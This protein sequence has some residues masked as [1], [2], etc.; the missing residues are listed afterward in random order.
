MTEWVQVCAVYD[1]E[2]K[3]VIRFD[4][5]DRTFTVYHSLMMSIMLRIVCALMKRFI[6]PR[7]L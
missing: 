7:G 4:H 3:D 1:I 5:S 6:L 2:E